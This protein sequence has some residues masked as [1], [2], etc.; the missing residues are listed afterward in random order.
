M[1]FLTQISHGFDHSA[2]RFPRSRS[3]RWIARCLVPGL[4]ALSLALALVLGSGIWE[5]SPKSGVQAQVLDPVTLPADINPYDVAPPLQ[6]P[7]ALELQPLDSPPL[8]PPPTIFPAPP[9]TPLS[10]PVDVPLPP[11]QPKLAAPPVAPSQPTNLAQPIPVTPPPAAAPSKPG[12]QSSPKP[13]PN[14]PTPPPVPQRPQFPALA[15]QEVRGVWITTN[16]IDVLLDR[17]RLRTAVDQLADLNFNT[18]Y[19]VVWNSGYTLHPSTV[20]SR[21]GSPRIYFGMQGQDPLTEVIAQ[22]HR[23]GLSVMPWFEFGFM[24]PPSSELALAHPDWLTQKA[25]GELTSLSAGGENAWLNPFRPEVQKFLTDLVVEVVDR[26]DVD[27]IQFD[28]HMALPRDFGYDSFTKAL[29]KKETG[30][31]VPTNAADEAWMRW[32]ADKITEFIGDLHDALKTRKPRAVFSVSPNYHDFAYKFTLQDWLAWVRRDFVDEIVMQVYRADYNSFV[33]QLERPEIREVR[34]KVSTGIGVLS[35]LPR[36]KIAISQVEQQSRAVQARG[37]GIVYFFYESL[38]DYAPEPI[39]ERQERFR[40]LFSR[41]APRLAQTATE[42]ALP[43]ALQEQG[44]I[45]KAIHTDQSNQLT[46]MGLERL[47]KGFGSLLTFDNTDE[48]RRLAPFLDASL[49]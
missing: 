20:A 8:S 16:D 2:G 9:L 21:A 31:D 37:L 4:G 15:P 30:K 42:L 26:Y 35:G 47:V 24:V 40:T 27:G 28:D 49:L 23:R 13:S 11:S 7:A 10:L 39:A 12:S 44:Q 6:A 36:R 18:L 38:W 3:R 29:Y 34:Q 33:E 48:T 5:R 25:N 14:A 41:P 22:G 19:P 17:D 45:V 1:R 46:A 43:V 32:R